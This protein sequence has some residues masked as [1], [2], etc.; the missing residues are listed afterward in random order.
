VKG[1]KIIGK[2]EVIDCDVVVL[3]AGSFIARLL[4]D[5]FGLICPVIPIKG[6]TFDI[7]TDTED[8]RV[9]FNFRDRAF[10]ATRLSENKWRIAA[11]GDIAG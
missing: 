11:F 3:C 8:K 5:N 2:N 9:H 1:V 7:P 10:V 6:Y 4:K